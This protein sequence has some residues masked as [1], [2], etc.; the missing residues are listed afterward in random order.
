MITPITP[1]STSPTPDDSIYYSETPNPKDFTDP[2]QNDRGKMFDQIMRAGPS[3]MDLKAEQDLEYW[4][5][6]TL[7][8][9]TY[10]RKDYA[11][12]ARTY[13]TTTEEIEIIAKRLSKEFGLDL[14][15]NE[16]N[17]MVKQVQAIEAVADAGLREWKLQAVARHFKRSKRELLE[18]Y[19]KALVNQAPIAPMKMSDLRAACTVAVSW[20]VQGWMPKGVSVL[21]HATGGTGK[22][23]FLYEIAAAIAKGQPWNDY[24][25]EQGPV[26]ILQSD[27]PNPVIESR[28]A[29]LEVDD[30][31]PFTVYR[32]WQVEGMAQ[33]EAY[34]RQETEQNRP[35]RFIVV[36]SI[37]STNKKTSISEND[38]EFARPVL[39][40]AELAERFHCTIAIV[41]HSNAN[42]DSRGTKAIHNAVS[43]V[44]AMSIADERTGDR[45]LRIQKNRLGRP[46]G[47][48]RF[49]FDPIGNTFTFKGEE[50]EEDAA[51]TNEK[52][53]ELWMNEIL[54]R[55]VPYD[56][57]EIAY[58]LA[59]PKDSV[60]KALSELWSKGLIMRT[61]RKGRGGGYL[62]YTG[63]LLIENEPDRS[64]SADQVRDQVCIPDSDCD[65]GELGNLI[66]KNAK[67]STIENEKVGDQAPKF[68]SSPETEAEKEIELDRELDRQPD[69][70]P[71]IANEPDRDQVPEIGDIVLIDSEA[72]LF[73][74]GSDKLRGHIPNDYRDTSSLPIHV[75]DQDLF[76]ELMEPS[77]VLS[78]NRRGNSSFHRVRVRNQRTGRNATFSLSDVTVISPTPTDVQVS[79]ETLPPSSLTPHPSP[80]TSIKKG[81]R[82]KY[83]GKFFALQKVCKGKHLEVKDLHDGYATVMHSE[84]FAPQTIPVSAL[85]SV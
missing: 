34:L 78:I 24:P 54:H 58:H 66:G 48:Y 82:V 28:L 57:E 1:T 42:G 67:N 32:D 69:R 26:L 18:A 15:K 76:L 51:A 31:L 27:E 72:T 29:T 21:L 39:Q 19:N 30:D 12:I 37:T 70:P 59:I 9:S 3:D 38:V 8:H 7:V 77:K 52:R 45:L 74:S 44:W 79:D 17:A 36:D 81:D 71:T 68:P 65:T 62:Y 60:R 75:L 50:G 23:L 43:E 53:I 73:R 4:V 47:R 6:Q 33:L 80:A 16:F 85:K 63:E 46:P 5:L 35:V 22:T 49:T 13:G 64:K 25:T 55:S 10:K 84:W 56:P 20:T 11:L 40:L 61:R 83:V 14:D 41:H 2:R